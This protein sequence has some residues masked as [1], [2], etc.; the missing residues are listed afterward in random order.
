MRL[1]I[2]RRAEVEAGEFLDRLSQRI[3]QED[4]EA[5]ADQV[6]DGQG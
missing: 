4:S 3:A 6:G 2:Y 5:Q 1:K